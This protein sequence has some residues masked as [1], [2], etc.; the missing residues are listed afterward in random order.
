M[1]FERWCGSLLKF[2]NFVFIRRLSNKSAVITKVHRKLYMKQY[3]TLMV[4]P[5]GST[6]YFRHYEPR[7]II[8]LPIDISLLSEEEKAEHLEKRQPKTKVVIEEDIIDD[9]DSKNYLKYMQRKQ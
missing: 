9:F 5:D 8:K 3:Q 1:L 7:R 6:F 2:N 4:Q